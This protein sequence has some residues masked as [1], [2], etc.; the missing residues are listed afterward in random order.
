MDGRPPRARTI[1][2]DGGFYLDPML[3]W[4]SIPHRPRL[5]RHFWR[6]VVA[7]VGLALALLLAVRAFV[8]SVT[9]NR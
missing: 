1:S 2:P 5:G 9:I 3:G 4:Q 8:A 7:G 6:T